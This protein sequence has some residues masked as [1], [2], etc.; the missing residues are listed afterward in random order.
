MSAV[1]CDTSA[2]F[3]LFDADDACHTEA[4]DAWRRCWNDATGLLTTNYVVVECTALLQRRL[5]VQAARDFLHGL[6]DDLTVEWVTPEDHRAASLAFL[7]AARRGPSLV[8][9]TSFVVMRRLGI[10][11]ALAFDGHFSDQ[12]FERPA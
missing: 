9:C 10:G 1:F 8:D 3:A 2:V 6:V 12:G 4:L 5:G 11:R 7:A